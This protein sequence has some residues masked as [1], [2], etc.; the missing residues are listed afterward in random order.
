MVS[1]QGRAI[2]DLRIMG[3][4]DRVVVNFEFKNELNNISSE[5]NIQ[6]IGYYIHLNAPYSRQRASMLLVTCIGCSYLQV[7][8]AVWNKGDLCVDPL[9]QPVSLLHVP[10][11]PTCGFTKVA[12]VLAAV[13]S[14]AN[15]LHRR[16]SEKRCG[17][18]F[19]KF[20]DCTITYKENIEGK[21]CLFAATLVYENRRCREA[22]VKFSMRY[23]IDVHRSL[24]EDNQAPEVIHF[25][26]LAGN[27]F[28][29]VMEKVNGRPL[30]CPVDESI[31]TSLNLVVEKLSNKN[32][33]HGDLRPQ[34][35]LL[36][37]DKSIRV[38]DFDS[39]GLAGQVKYPLDINESCDWHPHVKAG[40]VIIHCHDTYQIEKLTCS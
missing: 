31:K 14:T 39:S 26:K 21:P 27:W 37:P 22:V 11:D 24:A 28:V 17:S 2:P 23:G 15:D 20:D 32:F 35:I 30:Q 40:E 6:S 5:P 29:V 7:Y 13:N 10:Y 36:L 16:P 9:C 1:R 33:V 3:P 8:G 4:D 34:N 25:L 12:R 38:V 19:M 18:Y